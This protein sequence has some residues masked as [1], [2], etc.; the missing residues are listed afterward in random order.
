MGKLCA[1]PRVSLGGLMI[2]HKSS[3][4]GGGPPHSRLT[5]LCLAA[6]RAGP[7]GPGGDLLRALAR[8]V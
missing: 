7:E 8:I 4:L 5:A 2:L 3:A 1:V 6:T